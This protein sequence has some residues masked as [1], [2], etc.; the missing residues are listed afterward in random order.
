MRCRESVFVVKGG[1]V[2]DTVKPAEDGDG[3]VVRLFD[4]YGQRG[5]A[6]LNTKA[7]FKAV[8]RS[9]ILEDEC[10]PLDFYTE[11]CGDQGEWAC[12]PINYRPSEVVCLRF[13]L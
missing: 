8:C 5:R 6:T 2:L 13:L 10:G 4:P 1:L 12:V 9:N 11:S 7:P 3:F